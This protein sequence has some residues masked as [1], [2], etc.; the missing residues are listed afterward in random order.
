MCVGG[1]LIVQEFIDFTMLFFHEC[2]LGQWILLKLFVQWKSVI[3]DST[4][5]ILFFGISQLYFKI[6][7]NN[8]CI[9]I[10]IC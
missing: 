5:D 10:Y 9:Y 6:L 2:V 3:D 8:I 7:E 4:L 1:I